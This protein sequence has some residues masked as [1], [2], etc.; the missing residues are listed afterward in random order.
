MG[1]L[2]SSEELD[3]EYFNKLMNFCVLIKDKCTN[4][5]ANDQLQY[6]MNTIQNYKT[7]KFTFDQDHTKEKYK[8]MKKKW[9][10]LREIL[11]SICGLVFDKLYTHY[12][13]VNLYRF[14][15]IQEEI[16]HIYSYLEMYNESEAKC[17]RALATSI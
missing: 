16:I 2:N 15:Q 5:V 9:Y 4:P 10:F 17:Q 14:C 8:S 3:V 6:F 11:F 1:N 12:C 13:I 7:T